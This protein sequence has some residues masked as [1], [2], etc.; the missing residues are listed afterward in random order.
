MN[1]DTS[2]LFLVLL[3]AAIH[4]IRDFALKGT[5]NPLA[6]YFGYT[7]VWVVL[8]L[9][10]SL[11]MG[12]SL[13]LPVDV[14]WLLVVTVS[15]LILYYFGTLEALKRGDLSVYYPIIRS[16]PVVVLVFGWIAMSQAFNLMVTAGIGLVFVGTLLLQKPKHGLLSDPR[17]LLLALLAMLGSAAYT[18]SD[19]GAMR[20][21]SPSVYLFYTYILVG[22]GLGLMLFWQHRGQSN[23]PGKMLSGWTLHPLRT[24]IAGGMAYASYILILIAFQNG[25]DAA[26]VSAVRQASIPI[27]VVLG[28]VLLHETSMVR[29]LKWASL[30]AIG[31][32]LIAYFDGQ[33]G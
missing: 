29:R 18:L 5:G 14:W 4:P 3:S 31:I 1:S 17:S 23:L 9:S 6:S 27:S 19:A 22:T 15:G 12:H 11:I 7:A 25:A 16:S 20:S 8:G 13:V 10:Q 32:A 30:I 26:A 28:A 24:L 33:I 21:V 2:W